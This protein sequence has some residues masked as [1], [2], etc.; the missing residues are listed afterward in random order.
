MRRATGRIVDA[1][2][3]EER[4]TPRL[5]PWFDANG[6]NRPRFRAKMCQAVGDALRENDKCLGCSEK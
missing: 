4:T 3:Q 1:N 6:L 5:C 2:G